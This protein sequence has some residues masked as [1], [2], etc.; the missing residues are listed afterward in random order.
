ME[1]ATSPSSFVSLWRELSKQATVEMRRQAVSDRAS[2]QAASEHTV[3]PRNEVAADC[4]RIQQALVGRPD[5]VGDAVLLVDAQLRA[6]L[7]PRQASF[8][9]TNAATRT[10]AQETRIVAETAVNSIDTRIEQACQLAVDRLAANDQTSTVEELS[11]KLQSTELA[12]EQRFNLLRH[13]TTATRAIPAAPGSVD[14]PAVVSLRQDLHSPQ[15]RFG[16]NY[17]DHEDRL[18]NISMLVAAP[19]PDIPGALLAELATLRED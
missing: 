16:A 2:V 18:N 8:Q 12:A 15:A 1:R 7:T 6:D 17:D 4:S 9:R 19:S 11:K 5:G 14:S 13:E 3:E 10:A